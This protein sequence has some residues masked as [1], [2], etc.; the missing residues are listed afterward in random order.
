ML[1]SRKQCGNTMS[2]NVKLIKENYMNK[3]T[4]KALAFRNNASYIQAVNSRFSFKVEGEGT[5]VWTE[6]TKD[7]CKKLP[8]KSYEL[9]VSGNNNFW[10]VKT[11]E[12]KTL[13]TCEV[14][15][16]TNYYYRARTAKAKVGDFKVPHLCYGYWNC[17]P[18]KF[19]AIEEE[20]L[21]EMEA[22]GDTDSYYRWL[23]DRN[24]LLEAT[25]N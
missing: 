18:D 10:V 8:V 13:V 1:T 11:L 2:T 4:K 5:Y 24:A 21:A 17:F 14:E 6:G 12:G 23:I 3:N 19:K 9:V 22:N 20:D 15:L 25:Y 16:T 7:Y